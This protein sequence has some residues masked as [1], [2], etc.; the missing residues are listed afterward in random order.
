MN[1]FLSRTIILLF[2]T[3][4]FLQTAFAQVQQGEQMHSFAVTWLEAEQI[5]LHNGG[6][7]FMLWAENAVA[8]SETAALPWIEL[9]IESPEGFSIINIELKDII[10]QQISLSNDSVYLD[11]DAIPSNFQIKTELRTKNGS[12]KN[13]ITILPL[14]KNDLDI[15]KLIRATIHYEFQSLEPPLNDGSPSFVDNSVLKD[16]KWVRMAVTEDGIYGISYQKL[17]QMGFDMNHI[18]PRYLA[19]YGNGGQMLPESN[20]RFRHDDL[21]ENA[22]LVTGEEDGIFNEDDMLY[23]YGASPIEWQYDK[24]RNIY[25]HQINYYSDTTWYF[26]TLHEDKPGKRILKKE[27]QHQLPTI[28]TTEFIDRQFHE[29][30][31]VNL[32]LSGREWFGEIFSMAKPSYSFDFVFPDRIPNREAFIST[33]F[34]GRSITENIFFNGSINGQSIFEDILLLQINPSS[35]TFARDK[36][37][38]HKIGDDSDLLSVQLEMIAENESS[39]GWLNYININAWRLLKYHDKALFFRNPDVSG[40]DKIV[41]FQIEN[42]SA[43]LLL[44]NISNPLVPMQIDFELKPDNM[45]SFSDEAL[46]THEYV[47]FSPENYATINTFK[48]VKNQNLHALESCDMLIVTH[49]MFMEQAH[50]LA[51]IHLEEDG[52]NSQVVN[53][54]DVY[55]EFGSGS[56]DISALRDFVRMMY[57]KS[58]KTMKYLLLFGD[59]SYDYKDRIESNTNLI[60]TYQATNSLS[61]TYSY[62]SDDF[63]GLMDTH[64]GEEMSGILDIGIGRFPTN[65]IE[66]ADILINKLEQYIKN[67][68]QQSGEWRTNIIFMAD[69]S[70]N[71]AHLNQA[72]QLANYVDNNFSDLNISKV[73]LDAFQRIKVSGGYRFPD[74]SNKLIESLEE[75]ALIYNYTGHGGVNGLTNENVFSISHINALRNFNKLPFFITATCEFSRFDNP[76]LESAGEQLV[77]NPEGGCISLMTTT[78]QAFSHANFNLNQKLYAALFDKD[79]NQIARLGD[80]IRMSKIPS[81]SLIYNFVLLGDPALRLNYPKQKIVITSFNEHPADMAADT[82]AAMAEVQLKGII[83][84][85]NGNHNTEFQGIVDVRL[86]DKKTKHRTLGNDDLSYPSDFKFYNKLLYRGKLTVT[87]GSFS[88]QIKLPRNIAYQTDY[89]RFSFYAMDSIQQ[90]DAVGHFDNFLIG[91]DAAS[92]T[93]DNEGPQIDIFINDFSFKDGDIIAEG[94]TAIILLQDEDGINFLGN[95][96]GRDLSLTHQSPEQTN[97]HIVN[98]LYKPQINEFGKGEIIIRLEDNS[99]GTHKLIMKAWDLHNNSTTKEI[100]FEINPKAQIY[101]SNLRNAPNPFSQETL[102]L[103]DHNKPGQHLDIQLELFNNI[104]QR[105]AVLTHNMYC[106]GLKSEPIPLDMNKLL[107]NKRQSGIYF[108]K[109]TITDDFG[110]SISVPQKMIYHPLE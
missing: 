21:F 58:E 53:I 20:L 9:P 27:S 50:K 14:R 22:I 11:E 4:I 28:S 1:V 65:T 57:Y 15:E 41:S 74:A 98:S 6:S 36:L 26:L 25:T 48:E 102:I 107:G 44:W 100:S 72:E 45:L 110:N 18:D 52:L 93:P 7:A 73:Y 39:R 99:I 75:G 46:Q 68:D 92:I 103:F 51:Q 104:G 47:L 79:N 87:N 89:A 40:T 24:F 3:L 38:Q 32:I 12:L 85:Q 31:L 71:N 8:K 13:Y 61:D 63:F 84:D 30:D 2:S 62:V 97:H 70:D 86:F 10:I 55:I 108:Y 66:Q 49:P 101:I 82:L 64:E 60:P 90:I 81:N 54:Q 37:Q 42:A 83:L 19:V 95:D 43:D 105:L 17:Q 96:I 91:G 67:Q 56:S 35:S 69:D 16:G 33:H 78:R 59:A 80:L 94:A 29:L 88:M 109:L 5:A 34:A 77:F 23:F 76:S 106:S